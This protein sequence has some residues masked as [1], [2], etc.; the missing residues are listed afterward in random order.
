[1]STLQRSSGDASAPQSTRILL[2]SLRF[3]A[4]DE[5][6]SHR[7]CFCKAVWIINVTVCILY[8]AGQ[9]P[10]IQGLPNDAKLSISTFRVQSITPNLT[11]ACFV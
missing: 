6:G 3:L 1:M 4:D 7:A 8:G 9:L 11:V 2:F 10:S 5:L